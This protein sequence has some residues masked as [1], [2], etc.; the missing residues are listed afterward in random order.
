MSIPTANPIAALRG[1]DG[2]AIITPRGDRSLALG[3]DAQARFATI[4]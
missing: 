1:S 2:I 3:L 4:G